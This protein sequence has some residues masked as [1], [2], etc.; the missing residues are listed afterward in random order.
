MEH[1]KTVAQLFKDNRRREDELDV[2]I[3]KQQAYADERNS[4]GS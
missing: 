1:H 3:N 2:L 4:R